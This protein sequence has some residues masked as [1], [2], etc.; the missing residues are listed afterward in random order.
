MSLKCTVHQMWNGGNE[1][2]EE[3]TN[4]FLEQERFFKACDA[5]IRITQ[6]P[7]KKLFAGAGDV[8][9]TIVLGKEVGG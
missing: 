3:V 4:I 2:V 5:H 6:P 7:V 8:Y 1:I 9:S